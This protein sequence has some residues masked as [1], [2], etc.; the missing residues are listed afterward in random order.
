MVII[1]SFWIGIQIPTSRPTSGMH[2]LSE[3]THNPNASLI[4][5]P[6]NSSLIVISIPSHTP[7][8][9]DLSYESNRNTA[10]TIA[11]DPGYHYIQEDT[12]H[13]PFITFF[14]GNTPVFSMHDTSY[15]DDS[16]NYETVIL[17][18]SKISFN[19][20]A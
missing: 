4:P 13:L 10:T 15:E 12:G 2:K 1:D 20:L 19:F 7:G 6:A 18:G 16:P 9:L 17:P 8:Q 11:A 14:S 3:M 5:L